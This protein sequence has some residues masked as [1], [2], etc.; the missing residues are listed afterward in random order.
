MIRYLF[1]SI[2]LCITHCAAAQQSVPVRI[3][4]DSVLLPDH[5][6]I[7]G[8]ELRDTAQ[9]TITVETHLPAA[10]KNCEPIQH[11]LAVLLQQSNREVAAVLP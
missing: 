1:Y 8:P 10:A 3:F 5:I 7:L 4:R 6:I 11:P 2:F 9:Y